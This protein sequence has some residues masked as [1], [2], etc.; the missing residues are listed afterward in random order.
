MQ[1]MFGDQQGKSLP[2]Y[3][4]N[5]IVYSSSAEQHLQQLEVVHGWLQKEGL[6]VKLEKNVHFF[7]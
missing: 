2:F 4:D 1:R 7:K 5:I 3:L 6:K